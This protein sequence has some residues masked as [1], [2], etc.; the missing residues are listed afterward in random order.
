MTVRDQGSD[1]P[2]PRHGD[3]AAPV[4]DVGSLAVALALVSVAAGVAA[5]MLF[6]LS[7]PVAGG[8]ILAVVAL[9]AILGAAMFQSLRNASRAVP[10]QT[11]GEEIIAS[12]VGRGGKGFLGT[13]AAVVTP[14]RLIA[15][16]GN[17]FRLSRSW[18][19]LPLASLGEAEV[20]GRLPRCG[21]SGADRFG[22]QEVS[23]GCGSGSGPSDRIGKAIK[24]LREV[25]YNTV[26]AP[27]DH[28]EM[29]VAEMSSA[30]SPWSGLL[31]G[32]QR[33]Q[34]VKIDLPHS[35]PFLVCVERPSELL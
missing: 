10:L 31:R 21:G 13:H 30:K 14:Q 4:A 7:G 9:A 15:V 26:C 18:V 11:D 34:R 5:V 33:Y 35:G 27:S 17:P 2:S 20:A 6:I 32:G 3:P 24:S 22:D 29:L 19:V 28:A 1:N 8:I 12:G 25:L 16:P 23:T